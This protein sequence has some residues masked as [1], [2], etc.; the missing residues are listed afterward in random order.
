MVVLFQMHQ[1]VQ[2]ASSSGELLDSV[3]FIECSMYDV[4]AVQLVEEGYNHRA[5]GGL[6][7]WQYVPGTLL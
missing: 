6:L 1:H 3:L 7:Y 2:V 4:Y 5:T